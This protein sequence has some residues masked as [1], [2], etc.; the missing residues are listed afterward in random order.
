MLGDRVL[1]AMERLM[2]M[3][4]VMIG[5]QMLFNGIQEFFRL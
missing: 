1:V 3:I 4:L 2:G 5:V